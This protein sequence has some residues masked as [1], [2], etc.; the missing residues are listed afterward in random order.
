[1]GIC[2]YFVL[3]PGVSFIEQAIDTVDEAKTLLSQDE[4]TQSLIDGVTCE[5][6]ST[7]FY[8]AGF[9]DDYDTEKLPID[10]AAS[11]T[12]CLA[13]DGLE[14]VD[15]DRLFYEHFIFKFFQLGVGPNAI[16]FT[17][18]EK[19][20]RYA[21]KQACEE[22]MNDQA[23]Y[24]YRSDISKF[25]VFNALHMWDSVCATNEVLNTGAWPDLL[26]AYDAYLNVC[27]PSMCSYIQIDGIDKAFLQSIAYLGTVFPVFVL[28]AFWV[29]NGCDKL[30]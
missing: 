26:D 17:D 3:N 25:E 15:C 10:F 5:C 22:F 30:T 1:M 24:L 19:V 28:I 23:R 7:T 8:D 14:L 9:S 6:Q 27:A 20:T 16:S 11:E 4:S 13:A 12:T 29:Y 18:W 21:L 2:V